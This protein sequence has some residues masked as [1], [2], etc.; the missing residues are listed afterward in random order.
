[1]FS[2]RYERGL[3]IPGYSILHSHSRRHFNRPAT[4]SEQTKQ[5]PWPLVRERNIPTER[6]PLVDEI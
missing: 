3:Y 1:V 4:Y 6:P 5:T 2:V